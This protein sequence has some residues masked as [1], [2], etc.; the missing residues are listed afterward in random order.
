MIKI[1]INKWSI[2][3]VSVL[4]HLSIQEIHHSKN[5][6]KYNSIA[7]K[8][9]MKTLNQSWRK[10]WLNH[11][12]WITWLIVK[13]QF[14]TSRLEKLRVFGQWM[15]RS[16]EIFNMNNSYFLIENEIQENF[17]ISQDKNSIK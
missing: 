2:R 5:I 3:A 1:Y 4:N 9:M 16:W 8:T 17:K 13:K 7:H 12:D 6:M 11:I 10:E 15:N 14:D